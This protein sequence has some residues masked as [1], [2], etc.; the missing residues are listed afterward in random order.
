MVLFA[1]TVVVI[2][3]L[4]LRHTLGYVKERDI[5]TSS[6]SSVLLTNQRV[7]GSSKD[8]ETVKV[9]NLEKLYPGLGWSNIVKW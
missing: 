9:T 4:G 3:T 8:G 1:G 6:R 7:T 5:S 2:S